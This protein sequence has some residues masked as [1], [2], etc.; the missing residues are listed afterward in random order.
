MKLKD[1]LVEELNIIRNKKVAIIGAGP[2]IEEINELNEDIIIS[3]DGATNYLF[4][5]GISPDIVITDLDGINVYP[6]DSIYVVHAHG[7]NIDK[8]YKINY[9][10]KVIGSVQVY[11]FGKLHLF[12]GFTDGDR[13]VIIALLFDAKEIHLYG[14]DFT[15]GIVGRYSKPYYKQNLP[16]SWIKKNKLKIAK[17]IIEQV[18]S[19]DL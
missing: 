14:M 10:S 8:L 18:L 11:P 13:A 16:A 9:M 5:K 1:D 6:R 4:E 7:N 3:A 15:S 17:Q 2:N 12:G 19:K